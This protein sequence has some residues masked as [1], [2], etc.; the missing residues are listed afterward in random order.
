MPINF[1]WI[2]AVC[3][4]RL[5]IPYKQIGRLTYSQFDALYCE[6]K[7]LF[8]LEMLLTQSK[9]T[10]EKMEKQAIDEAGWF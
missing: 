8:D 5:N 1:S 6:Y 7:N 3:L 10:Y 4:T 9:T 2:Y